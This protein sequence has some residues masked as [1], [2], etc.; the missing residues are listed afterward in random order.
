[1]GMGS[2]RAEKNEAGPEKLQGSRSLKAKGN[3][4]I[5][6]CVLQAKH[7][8]LLFWM[9]QRNC[10]LSAAHCQR[11]CLTSPHLQ[12]RPIARAV[13]AHLNFGDG[14]VEA[15]QESGECL[16]FNACTD[17]KSEFSSPSS[18]SLVQSR[19]SGL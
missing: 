13:D 9:R 3:P 16:P 4:I 10:S 5:H 1:M 2:Q 11:F 6:A 18:V 8:A 14:L 15:W 12:V 17:I 19:M 7:P